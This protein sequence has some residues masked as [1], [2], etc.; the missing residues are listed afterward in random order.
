MPDNN[1]LLS[2]ITVGLD[3]HEILETLEPLTPILSSSSLQSIVVVPVVT[4]TMKK[5]LPHSKF[6][7]DSG[8]GVYLAMNDG[9]RFAQGSYVWFLNAGDQS[10]IDPIGMHTLLNDLQKYCFNSSAFSLPIIFFCGSY[11]FIFLSSLL[12]NYFIKLSLFSLGMPVSHQNI[13]VPLSIHKSFSSHYHFSSDFQL[14]V[15]LIFKR[16]TPFLTK[17]VKISHLSPNGISDQNRL[18]VFAE[19]FQIISQLHSF[20]FF[21]FFLS[22]YFLRCTRE[23]LARYIKS[24]LHS[25]FFS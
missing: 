18:L 24:L 5:N 15:D 2:I 12:G 8:Q 21:P 9:L 10:L 4:N 14:L 13:L 17:S 23:I 25:R 16:S 20:F 1:I 11:P 3:E 22:M 7:T 6:L 19:R